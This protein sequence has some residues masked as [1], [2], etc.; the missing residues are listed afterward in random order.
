MQKAA[1]GLLLERSTPSGSEMF[2]G[3]S[4]WGSDWEVRDPEWRRKSG[5]GRINP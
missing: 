3:Y 5:S 2:T 1:Q 4:P